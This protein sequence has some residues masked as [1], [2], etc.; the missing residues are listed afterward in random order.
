MSI[1]MVFCKISPLAYSLIG[2]A[3]SSIFYPLFNFFFIRFINR[4]G[5]KILIDDIS[6]DTQ[7]NYSTHNLRIENNSCTHIKGLYVYVKIID[8]KDGNIIKNHANLKTFVEKGKVNFG[9]LSWAK[10]INNSNLPNNNLNQGETADVNFIRFHNKEHI[11]IASEHGFSEMDKDKKSRI[12]LNNNKEYKFE[13]TVTGESMFRKKKTLKWDMNKLEFV[14][15]KSC[16]PHSVPA[17]HTP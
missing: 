16:S 12:L 17:N 8:L 1:M 10:N 6:N 4:G 3:V 7:S 2:G 14:K 15:G 13:I 9:M 11:E 5:I